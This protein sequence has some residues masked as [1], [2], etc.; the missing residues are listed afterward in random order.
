MLLRDVEKLLP[1]F[2]GED[3]VYLVKDWIGDMK[4]MATKYKW[5]VMETVISAKKSLR[6]AAT[7][8]K[9]QKDK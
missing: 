7:I 3:R 1:R 5:L 8:W 4:K 9:G 2:Y 6:G